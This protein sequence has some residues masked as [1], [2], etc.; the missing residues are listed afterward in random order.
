[1][2]YGHH[3]SPPGMVGR[4][5]DTPPQTHLKYRPI[6]LQDQLGKL[7]FK[8]LI[9]PYQ[10]LIYSHT[11]QYPQYGY[12]PG[13][14]HKDALRRVFDH[15]YEV[16]SQRQARHCNLHDKFDR[17]TVRTMVW[18]VQVTLDLAGAFGHRLLEGMQHLRL[19]SALIDIVMCWHQQAHYQLPRECDRDAL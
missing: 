17:K 18:G 15:C 16:R 12:T 6:G 3:T 7:T 5:P 11:M 14:S 1:M 13:R 10:S 19:P 4:V 9:E 2:E 8:A